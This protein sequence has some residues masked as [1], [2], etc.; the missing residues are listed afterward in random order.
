MYICLPVVFQKNI[1]KEVQKYIFMPPVI[2]KFNS[3]EWDNG[4][5]VSKNFKSET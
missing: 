1:A 4:Q 2:N 3:G 5:K